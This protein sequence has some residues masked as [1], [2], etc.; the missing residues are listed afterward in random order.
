MR[1]F[2]IFSLAYMAFAIGLVILLRDDPASL[3][4]FAIIKT[5]GSARLLAEYLILFS[6]FIA[7]GAYLTIKGN[8]K[9]RVIPTLYAALGCLIFSASFSFVK[10]SIPFIIPF[11]ADPALANLDLWLHGG[12]DPYVFT[13]MLAK[14]IDPSVVT[15]FYFGLWTLPAFFLPVILSITDGDAA[16]RNRFLVLHLFCWIGLGNVVA[17]AASSV[18]PIYYDLLLG[19]D[20]FAGLAAAIDASGITSSKIGTVQSSLWENYAERGQSIGSGISAFPSVHVAVSACLALYM[21]E[22]HVWLA[23]LGFGFL[24]AISFFSVYHGWHYA[25]DGYFSIFAVTGMWVLQRKWAGLRRRNVAMPA[26]A[27]A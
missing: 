18:G 5:M 23:P 10:T 16:R 14:Y 21:L 17:G 8:I 1:N 20:R 15:L 7:I 13:H 9:A 2:F 11:Y 27:A 19:T 24:A 6:V 3:F 4:Q 22:R 25:V 12:T 26:T